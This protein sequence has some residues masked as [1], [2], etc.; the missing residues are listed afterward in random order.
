MHKRIKSP[1]FA[2]NGNIGDFCM[3]KL[4]KEEYAKNIKKRKM[5][6]EIIKICQ[7]TLNEKNEKEYNVKNIIFSYIA[8]TIGAILMATGI[9]LFLVPNELSTG[10]FS[11][12]SLIVYY[13]FKF[14]LGT[15]ML[16][17]N[18]PL[19]IIAFFKISKK[20]FFRSIYGTVM[21]A[22]FIDLLDMVNPLTQDRF[23]ACIYG[24]ILVGIGTAIILKLNGSTGG[25]DLLSYVIRAY[26]PQ[27]R[28]SNLILIIDF[29]IIT[30]NVFVF[31]TIEVG[32]YSTIAIYL[33]GKMIDIIFEGT[34]FAKVLLIIS[35]KYKEISQQIGQEVNRGSTGIMSKGMYTNEEKMT[36]LC[37][38]SRTEAYTIENIAK[39]I[40]KGAF[41]III[42]AREV[43]GKGF[44]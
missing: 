38:G 20:L 5:R 43:L 40:D 24:G 18:I 4:K 42:N 22:T 29:I 7:G 30:I 12:V 13:L 6:N 21:L 17:L 27:Y 23:L 1:I 2:N 11:G 36:L 35:P 28:S 10:G 8:I 33:M 3:S 41:I 14:P 31:K 32:L 44:K 19:L 37:V 15:T 25:S 39:K 9:A 16:I 26:K 34:N